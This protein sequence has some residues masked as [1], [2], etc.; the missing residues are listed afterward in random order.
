MKTKYD[1]N[2]VKLCEGIT[3]EKLKEA[4][5]TNHDPKWWYFCRSINEDNK[6]FDVTFNVSID[7]KTFTKLETDILDEACLQPCLPYVY[8]YLGEKEY[9]SCTPYV[10]RG[11]KKCDDI[12]Q[13]LIDNKIIY[14][15][16]DE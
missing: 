8:Y 1:F 11:I 10:Q 14:F 2:H 3:A 12:I 15:E 13:S 6:R 16:G 5:F 7:S 9:E 4:G